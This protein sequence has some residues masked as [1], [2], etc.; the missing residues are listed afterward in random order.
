ME[1]K[2]EGSTA[3]AAPK[4][5]TVQEYFRTPETLTP[6]ELIYGVLRVADSP[7]PRHQQ[8][9]FRLSRRMGD[10]VDRHELGTVW[11]AP[12]DVILDYERHLVVQPDLF[13]ITTERMPFVPD[14]IRLAPDLVIEVLSPHPRI[15][16]LDE[17]LGWFAAYGVSECWLIHQLQQRTEV[18][19]F[20]EGKIAARE[21]FGWE[22]PLRSTVLP[23]FRPINYDV[24]G[25]GRWVR[26]RLAVMAAPLARR[27]D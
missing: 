16:E 11:I 9:I 12:L 13:Y 22:E 3:V 7:G 24:L 20:A 1:S 15:G 8:I 23:E 27:E 17:R 4:L 10:H 21:S 25:E 2:R 19:Q 18:L 14:R 6:Q 5:M 26:E